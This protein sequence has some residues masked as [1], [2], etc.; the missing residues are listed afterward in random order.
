M[1]LLG[2]PRCDISLDM[3]MNLEEGRPGEVSP[4]EGLR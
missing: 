4:Y 2:G 3:V 1:T